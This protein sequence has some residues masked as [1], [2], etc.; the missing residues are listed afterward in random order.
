MKYSENKD[1]C[2]GMERGENKSFGG[3][4]EKN[5]S[6]DLGGGLDWSENKVFWRWDG[7]ERRIFYFR[8]KASKVF[9]GGTERRKNKAFSGEME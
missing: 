8:K 9:D 7:K 6:E 5:K 4:M 1:F 3:E 2:G